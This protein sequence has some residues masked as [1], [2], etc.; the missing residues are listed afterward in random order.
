MGAQYP[1]TYL[2]IRL[3]KSD[4]QRGQPN[5]YDTLN[6]ETVP[7]GKSEVQSLSIVT[8]EVRVALAK[9]QVGFI[10]NVLEKMED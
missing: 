7:T 9:P 2:L 5:G 3:A 6:R 8:P 1:E 10:K 4:K